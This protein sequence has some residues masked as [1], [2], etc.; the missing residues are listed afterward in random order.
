MPPKLEGSSVEV[1][2]LADYFVVEGHLRLLRLYTC[3]LAP[4][5]LHLVLRTFDLTFDL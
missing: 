5:T 1:V 2:V 4:A 3:N